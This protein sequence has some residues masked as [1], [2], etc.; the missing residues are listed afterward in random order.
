MKDETLLANTWNKQAEM[1]SA[2]DSA[3]VLSGDD[4]LNKVLSS[5]HERI[6]NIIDFDIEWEEVNPFKIFRRN[7][8]DVIY[9]I[10][11]ITVDPRIF[12]QMTETLNKHRRI[13][14]EWKSDSVSFNKAA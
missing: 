2:N 9:S 14:D 1:T 3:T 11:W 4:S 6:S 12:E 13:L 5:K 10:L 7:S 8:R